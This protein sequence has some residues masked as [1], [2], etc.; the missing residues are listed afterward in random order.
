MLP[1]R[2]KCRACHEQKGEKGNG[3]DYRSDPHPALHAAPRSRQEPDSTQVRVTHFTATPPASASV[4]ILPWPTWA[5]VHEN[6]RV[7][8]EGKG[9]V[10][11]VG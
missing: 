1:L 11:W 5:M 2:M 10:R 7:T 3:R 6:I 9:K 8:G 4:P